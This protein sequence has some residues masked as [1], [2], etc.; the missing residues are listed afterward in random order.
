MSEQGKSLLALKNLLGSDPY[1]VRFAMSQAAW[2][3]LILVAAAVAAL[4]DSDALYLAGSGAA[5]AAL[6]AI[7]G[8]AVTPAIRK[9]WAAALTCAAWMALAAAI[10]AST[11]G[12]QS[13][14]ILLFMAPIGL[15][16]LLGRRDLAKETALMAGLVFIGCLIAA[17]YGYID[18]PSSDFSFAAALGA[19]VSLAYGAGLMLA[20]QVSV[21]E[22]PIASD[23]DPPA[24][25]PRYLAEL[26]HELKT[27]LNAIIG[28]ADVMRQSVFGKLPDKY[29]EYVETIHQ[30]GRHMLEVIT[31][32]LDMSRIRAGGYSLNPEILDA[33]VVVTET[34]QMMREAARE[35]GVSIVAP[36]LPEPLRVR[37]DKT[38]LKQILTNLIV[39]GLKYTPPGGSVTVRAEENGALQ[40]VVSD[41]GVGIPQE[42]LER[43]MRPFEQGP[44]AKIG[45]GL[46]LAVVRGLAELHGGR[47]EIDSPPGSGAIVT[48]TLPVL[49]KTAA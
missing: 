19:L 38:A 16:R 36:G 13:P 41:T 5:F 10:A 24:V 25:A 39:N 6:P 46:G 15:A 21:V 43:V 9:E 12:A 28:F 31:N 49:V 42:A 8:L 29:A 2:L 3:I 4:V 20:R 48:V 44:S 40:L 7:L 35:V 37:A 34:V 47:V 23:L 26:A 14:F 1:E 45:A 11:G 30:S 33:R 32:M 27:P 18:P 22:G 17:A